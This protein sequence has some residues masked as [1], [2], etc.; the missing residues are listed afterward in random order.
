MALLAE[1]LLLAGHSVTCWSAGSPG[2]P[3][4][5]E[6]RGV[7]RERTASSLLFAPAV[8]A[9]LLGGEGRRFD[10]IVEEVIGGERWP[11]L[12]WLLSSTPSV[13]MW[14]QDNRPLFAFTYGKLGGLLAGGVQSFLLRAFRGRYLLT[15]SQA[16]RSWLLSSGIPAGHVGVHHPMVRLHS[17][18]AVQRPYAERDDLFVCIGKFQALK[19]F[20]EAVQVHE[21]LTRRVPAARLTLLG[22]EDDAGYLR[23][24]RERI[25]RSSKPDQIQLLLNASDEQKFQLLSRAKALTIHSPIEGFGWTVPEAGLC[26]VPTI[27]NEG[28]PSDAVREGINGRKLRFGDAE[29]YAELLQLWMTDAA[30]W[31]PYSAG[32]IEVAREFATEK[33]TMDFDRIVRAASAAA[34]PGR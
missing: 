11:F 19:R 21:L 24:V 16:T 13:G 8:W 5:E 20:E 26:G 27:A 33:Q 34:P 3:A 14:Y 30:A 10:V 28:T 12:A 22:R 31:Q 4:T 18:G 23:S 32:A 9:R 17:S 6:L 7:V 1:D 29:G 15:P 2:L 25:R